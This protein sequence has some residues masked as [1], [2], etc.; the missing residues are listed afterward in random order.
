MLHYFQSV[1]SPMKSI[2]IFGA[3]FCLHSDQ[4]K[5][6]G[7]SLNHAQITFVYLLQRQRDGMD[8]D[9]KSSFCARPARYSLLSVAKKTKRSEAQPESSNVI[10]QGS[11]VR[12]SPSDC[13]IDRRVGDPFEPQLTSDKVQPLSPTSAWCWSTCS[14]WV[15]GTPS[16]RTSTKRKQLVSHALRNRSIKWNVKR[17]P[18]I[19]SFVNYQFIYFLRSSSSTDEWHK[20]IFRA[21]FCIRNTIISRDEIAERFWRR[22]VET[23]AQLSIFLSLP[24]TSHELLILLTSCVGKRTA[25]NL[26]WS[27][28]I[29]NFDFCQTHLPQKK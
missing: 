24:P 23:A 6:F 20:W 14:N 11:E 28:E 25:N 3:A 12:S 27:C 7:K 1:L 17:A 13:I 4:G 16:L 10:I 22:R 21:F 8:S 19:E 26:A 29:V 2:L 9:I 18:A 5:A 15:L